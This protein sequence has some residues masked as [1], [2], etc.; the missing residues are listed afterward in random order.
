MKFYI[1]SNLKNYENVNY[2]AN[3]LRKN[4]W[5]H[6]FNWTEKI[7]EIK[8]EKDLIELAKIEKKAI[9]DSDIVIILLP[10]GRGTHIELGLALAYGKKVYLCFSEEKEMKDAVNFYHLPEIIK[11]NGSMGNIIH[12]IMKIEGVQNGN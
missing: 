6:T 1:G 8:S 10:A 3:E 5:I 2:M 9:K 12:K 7:D 11:I 4:G